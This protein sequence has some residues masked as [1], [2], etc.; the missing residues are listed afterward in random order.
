MKIT[1]TFS[2]RLATALAFTG[3]LV[4]V[5]CSD[6]GLGKRYSVSGTVTYKGQPLPK[7]SIN[8]TSEKADGRGATGEIKNGSYTLT[9]QNPGDGAFEGGYLVTITDLV[10]DFAAADEES[11]KQAEK[12]HVAAPVMPDQAAVAKAVSNAKN[13]VPPKYSTSATSGLKATVKAES[14][15]IDFTLED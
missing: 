12:A 9:T 8:F 5:G 7:G 2:A 10:V 3:L 6:D 11:K 14:N 1:R 4:A 13:S 15:K